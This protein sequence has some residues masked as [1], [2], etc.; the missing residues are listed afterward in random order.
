[1]VNATEPRVIHGERAATDGTKELHDEFRAQACRLVKVEKCPKSEVCRKLGVS[2]QPLHDWLIQGFPAI[3]RK[4]EHESLSYMSFPREHWRS[5]RTNNPLERLK[6]AV[7]RFITDS[8]TPE[9]GR[10][11]TPEHVVRGLRE[12]EAELAPHKARSRYRSASHD[13]LSCL[14]P[15]QFRSLIGVFP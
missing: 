11:H 9:R 7:I 13:V 2:Y 5:L 14:Q 4:G 1:M 10:S 8:R 12:A 6:R 15:G 3:V